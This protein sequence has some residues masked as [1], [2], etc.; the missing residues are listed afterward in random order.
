M[1]LWLV[2]TILLL[3]SK[4][5]LAQV[6]FDIEIDKI[7]IDN[8]NSLVFLNDGEINSYKCDLSLYEVRDYDYKLYSECY[9]LRNAELINNEEIAI[10]RLFSGSFSKFNK[11]VRKTIFISSESDD[12]TSFIEFISDDLIVE[13]SRS[14]NEAN[15]FVYGSVNFYRY[16]F[17]RVNEKYFIMALLDGDEIIG[18]V[19]T[20]DNEDIKL[21][22]DKGRY[23][24]YSKKHKVNEAVFQAE[25]N[26]IY[27]VVKSENGYEVRDL[28]FQERLIHKSY[29][30]IVINNV[31]RFIFCY[32]ESLVDVY[33]NVLIRLNDEDLRAAYKM[34]GNH[35]QCINKKNE[36]YWLD[37]LG[38]R[39]DSVPEYLWSVCGTVYGES[40]KIEKQENKFE[41]VSNR[42]DFGD[43]ETDTTDLLEINDSAANLIYL[44][45]QIFHTY[46]VNSDIGSVFS[47]PY[48]YFIYQDKH[49]SKVLSITE[50]CDSENEEEKVNCELFS[51][52]KYELKGKIEPLGYYHPISIASNNLV[53]YYPQNKFPKYKEVGRFLYYFARIVDQSGNT[54]WLDIDGNEY[55]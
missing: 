41:Q 37:I 46:D 12:L 50:K 22:T 35:I 15:D 33:N 55:F 21:I 8:N 13:Y 23:V 54:G 32:K 28:L 34:P 44:N 29:D 27:R 24:E 18:Y 19:L 11:K 43:Q 2:C 52:V 10:S 45:N 51:E 39:T 30:S 9:R 49:S 7:Y 17:I 48:A 4:I 53:G 38:F 5:L 6:I 40:R 42:G 16:M 26:D 47:F 14:D 25:A 31:N 3:S 36:M 1:K 20:G